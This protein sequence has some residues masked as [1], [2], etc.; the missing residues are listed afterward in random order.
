MSGTY[1]ITG[2]SSGIGLSTAL[3]LAGSDSNLVLVARSAEALE[4]AQ[5]Q[6]QELG[7]RC[8][9]V[10]ADVRDAQAVGRAL[11]LATERFGALDGV[12]HSA[13][14]AAFGRFEDVPDDVFA[15]TLNTNVLGTAVVA[16]AALQRFR[17]QGH[18]RLVVLGSVLGSMAAPWMSPYTAS[19]WAINGLVRT[20][21]IETR[22]NRRITVSLV[23]PGGV[24]TPIYQL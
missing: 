22:D 12:V 13:A 20:L 9:T 8:L 4:A 18:G 11:H 6:C 5:R 17:A 15:A 2:A 3:R 16:R 7:G 1:C 14:V 21:Q 10:T 24:D 19:K 23:S